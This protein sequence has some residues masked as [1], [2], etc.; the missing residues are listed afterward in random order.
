[1]DKPY[2]VFISWSGPRSLVVAEFLCKW[3]PS[4]IQAAR[5]WLSSQSI[6]K[7]SRN[8]DEIAKAL[9]G[10]KCGITC[11]TPENLSATWI[12]YEAGA[13]SKTIDEKTRLCTYLL[14][15]LQPQ[16]VPPPLGWFQAT[17]ADKGDTRRLLQTVNT[18]VSEDPIPDENLDR[19]FKALWP[20]LEETLNKL[21]PADQ[22]APAKR[23][24]DDMVAEILE[25]TRAEAN[26]RPK[27]EELM[28]AISGLYTTTYVST[29][30]ATPVVIPVYGG[31]GMGP[32]GPIGGQ[33]FQMPPG[34]QGPSPPTVPL[35]P[36]GPRD[37]GPRPTPNADEKTKLG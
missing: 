29:V 16:E 13:L 24:I 36:S 9:Q 17:K 32:H 20:D 22:G 30:G 6:Q 31:R 10:S 35:G 12:L 23:S 34:P 21:P 1:M 37:P 3:L 19:V 11:L 7:G 25:I 14:G 28:R 2:N 26:T 5:P 27:P 33:E 4:V 8:Q 15:G 18:A